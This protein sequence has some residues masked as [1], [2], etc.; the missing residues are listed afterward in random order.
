MSAAPPTVSIVTIFHN[1]ERFL[2][3]TIRSVGLQSYEDWQLILVDD[4]SRDSSAAI[5]ERA[6]DALPE[7][8]VCCSHAGRAN[9]GMSASRNRGAKE[10]HGRFITFLDADDVWPPEKLAEQVTILEAERDA[11]MV[12]G[13]AKAW[14]SWNPED[15]RA[16]H[17]WDLGV[18]PNRLVEPPRLFE[19]LMKNKAQSPMSGNALIRRSVFEKVGGFDESFRGLYEDAVFFAKINL[20]FPAYVSDR[21]WLYYRQ[22]ASSC[23]AREEE[24]DYE[25][26][27]SAFLDWVGGYLRGEGASAPTAAHRAYARELWRCRH[28]RLDKRLK[29]SPSWLM[30]RMPMSRM[31]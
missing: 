16:D 22:H 1:A 13:R 4:G 28:P 7:R 11:A 6:R 29:G 31:P 9:R 12:Y 17:Y 2:E 26:R 23:M 5:A 27:R 25:A 8:I 20:A 15:S 30:S 14:F 21:T 3:E 19:L 24:L 18:T 10:A